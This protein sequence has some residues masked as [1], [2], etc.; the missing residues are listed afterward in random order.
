MTRTQP[1][2]VKSSRYLADIDLDD[3]HYQNYLTDIRKIAQIT[4]DPFANALA[5]AASRAWS[6]GGRSELLHVI[7][8]SAQTAFDQGADT[9]VRVGEAYMR[10]EQPNRA[11]PY[12][13]AAFER[14]DPVLM[15]LSV[16]QC[17]AAVKN[18]PEYRSLFQQVRARM[19]LPNAKKRAP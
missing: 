6:R 8:K 1:T 14:N 17:P 2:L 15:R 12:F 3:G 9:G 4:N 5:T 11:L 16:C 13:R 7:L 18:D 19:G 10:L